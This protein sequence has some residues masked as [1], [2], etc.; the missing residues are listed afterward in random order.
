MGNFPE[1]YYD[2]KI[3]C[4]LDGELSRQ[5]RPTIEYLF[6]LQPAS[7]KVL[8]PVASGK[9]DTLLWVS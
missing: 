6:S 7:T 8:K 3:P 4:P 5:A 2:P 1:T 9:G